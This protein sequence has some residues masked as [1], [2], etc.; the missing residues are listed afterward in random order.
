MGSMMGRH[1]HT[2]MDIAKPVP[3]DQ[4]SEWFDNASSEY[5]H[6]GQ[7]IVAAEVANLAYQAGADEQLLLCVDWLSRLGHVVLAD[8]LQSAMR[9]KPLSFK[10]RALR[11]LDT[12]DD[13]EARHEDVL[14][15]RQALCLLSEEP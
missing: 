12:L 8:E 13:R 14:M 11:V 9:P 4:F 3:A 15:I 5:S 1:H 7:R 2:V 10:Q 6:Y